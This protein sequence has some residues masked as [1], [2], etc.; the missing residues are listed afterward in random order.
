M[1]ACVNI[2]VIDTEIIYFLQSTKTVLYS[3]PPVPAIQ[4]A[5]S[6]LNVDQKG[7]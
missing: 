3:V 1:S 7:K 2:K 5:L 4:E 6:T